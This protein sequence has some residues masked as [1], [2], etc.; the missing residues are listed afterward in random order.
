MLLSN[1]DFQQLSGLFD[2]KLNPISQQLSAIEGRLE[3]VENHLDSVEGRLD[4]IEVRLDSVEGRLDAVETHLGE[5]DKKFNIMEVHLGEL[6]EKFNAME[7]HLGELDEKFYIAD[8]RM[9]TIQHQIIL[10][11]QKTEL[12]EKDLS[13]T[14][15]MV[16]KIGN[17]LDHE[18]L[19]RLGS[20]YDGYLQN[21]D[22]TFR[23]V[24]KIEADSLDEIGLLK[25]IAEDHSERIN[26]LESRSPV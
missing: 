12:I 14:K 2:I 13:G 8:K 3:T 7:V 18:V 5:L 21:K 25:K 1:E 22:I 10:L 6:D 26:K 15:E 20:L 9:D 19:P 11:M 4:T 24:T 17:T 23:L 16:S